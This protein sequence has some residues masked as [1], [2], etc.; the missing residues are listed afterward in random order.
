MKLRT[1]LIIAFITVILAP[2]LM[3]GSSF[4]LMNHLQL[5]VLRD[6]YGIEDTSELLASD[7]IEML[8]VMTASMKDDV[9][10]ILT[11]NKEALSDPAFL[12]NLNQTLAERNTF[13]IIRKDGE[14]VYS[15][16]PEVGKGLYDRL[17]GF[18]GQTAEADSE[19][20][21]LGGKF[22]YLISQQ[23]FLFPNQSEGSLFLITH[24]GAVIPEVS[25]ILMDMVYLIILVLVLT[26]V[27]LTA[28]IYSSI[29]RPLNT[30]QKAT[31]EIRDGNL[32]FALD[33]QGKDEI[34]ELCMDFEQMRRRLKES[35]EE[36]LQIDSENKVLI[37]NI[38]HDLKTPI[39]AIKGYVEGIMDGVA[40]SPEKLD[41]Y[42]RIIYNKAN[43]MARLIDELT[44]YSKIDTNRIPYNFAKINVDNYFS[45]CAEEMRLDLES[46]N[47]ELTYYNYLT[48]DVVIIGDGEQLKRVVN[49]IIGNSVKYLDKK[50]GIINIRI[51]DAGDFVQIEIEDNGRGIAR[52]DLPYI[53]DRFY[54]AD[55]SRNSSTG[56]S[57]IGLSIVRKIIEDHG[58][59]IWATSRENTGTIMHFVL[60]KYQEVHYE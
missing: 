18:A 56:G 31:R 51:R 43:D 27:G 11:E 3:V 2:I 33:V 6:T 12:E 13:L 23:D 45:D 4:L 40:S 25:G 46:K 30:L 39:T 47:I 15:G 54:R 29:I 7:S 1:K 32:D 41:K 50:K 20:F 42:I 19:G 14:I 53:F 17:P 28:W 5:R 10:R 49:N 16:N 21:Y 24:V 37:S 9:K 22:Q 36:K 26:A 35:A 8:H 58:G 44:L 52:K 57:G 34:S 48:E 55:A 38:T 59:R 60:R